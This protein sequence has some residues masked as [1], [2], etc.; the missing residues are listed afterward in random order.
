MDNSLDNATDMS[1]V[2]NSYGS[3]SNGSEADITEVAQNNGQP[4]QQDIQQFESVLTGQNEE[5]SGAGDQN[6]GMSVHDENHSGS[7]TA[8]DPT[9]SGPATKVGPFEKAEL[10]RQIIRFNYLRKS[11]LNIAFQGRH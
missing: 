2:N 5:L 3:T 4:S 9:A 1:S 7:I 8:F 11:T 6:G 10:D